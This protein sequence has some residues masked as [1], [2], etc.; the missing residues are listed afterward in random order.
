MVYGAFALSFDVLMIPLL[1]D[2]GSLAKRIRTGASNIVNNE[3]YLIPAGPFRASS[4][5]GEGWLVGL[6]EMIFSLGRPPRSVLI[7]QDYE[8]G[9]KTH[10][11]VLTLIVE[12]IA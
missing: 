9:R 1:R 2:S 8:V 7:I 11:L 5:A 6:L 4:P 3:T 10:D 12:D